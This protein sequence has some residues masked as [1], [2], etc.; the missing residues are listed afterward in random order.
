MGAGLRWKQGGQEQR[1][2]APWLPGERS[3][4]V[5]RGASQT[6]QQPATDGG[7]RAAVVSLM[8]GFQSRVVFK[9]KDKQSIS[10]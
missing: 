7:E 3:V 2:E 1:P 4:S 8:H 10:I 6:L 9:I 5:E